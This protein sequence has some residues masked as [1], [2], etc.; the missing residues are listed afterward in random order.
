M[1]TP[2]PPEGGGLPSLYGSSVEGINRA[3]D[4]VSRR[5]LLGAGL[6]LPMAAHAVPRSRQEGT[7]LERAIAARGGR[8]LIERVRAIAWTGTY[9]HVTERGLNT[10]AV[11]TSIE[12]FGR[13]EIEERYEGEAEVLHTIIGPAG[14]TAGDGRREPRTLSEQK[15]AAIRAEY[16]FYG[17]LLLGRSE[18]SIVGD[19]LHSEKPGF[20]P[21]DF[22]VAPSGTVI[23]GYYAAGVGYGGGPRLLRYALEGEIADHG[24]RWPR[25]ITALNQRGQMDHQLTL[26]TLSITLA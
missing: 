14:G 4:F 11:R 24:L 3:A 18:T 5:A 2:T 15:V 26:E 8:A 25:R 23:A 1:D 17:Y 19:R 21:I 13:I 9:G 10:I 6:T 22:E 16:G 7:L 12:P 20:P